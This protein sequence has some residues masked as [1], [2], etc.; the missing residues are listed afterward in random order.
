MA[1]FSPSGLGAL[2]RVVD[3]TA[4][5]GE[6]PG[7][8]GLVS[9]GGETHVFTAGTLA[10]G[11]DRPMRRDTLFRITS[12]TK[13]VTAA[14]AMMLIEEG[15]LALEDPVGRLAPELAV[16]TVLPSLDAP[17]S[18][19]A[20]SPRP[21]TVEDVM[22]FRLGWGVIMAPPGT[23]PVQHVIAEQQ[24][25]G[26]G[27]PDPSV[28]YGPDEYLRRLGQLPLFSPPGRDWRYTTGSNVMGALIPRA[29]GRPLP[30]VFKERIFEPLGMSDTAFHVPPDKLPRLPPAYS[31]Q[32]VY[33]PPDGAW[34]RRPAFPQGDSG[35]VST[36]DDFAAFARF[37]ETGRDARGRALLSPKS[38]AAMKAN[39]LTP[40][41]ARRGAPFLAPG[42][43]WGYG[44]GVM[45]DEN[46]QGLPVG[47]YGWMGGFG[48]SWMTEPG[49]GL[50]ALLMTQR[51]LDGPGGAAMHT[52]FHGAAL[53]AAA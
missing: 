18:A 29:A 5:R 8:V 9:R 19:A 36:A 37:L 15:A 33:D 28:P 48:T 13:P 3:E 53:A 11:G 27:P 50:I 2:Q 30:E 26:F 21:M 14:A 52:A 49:R 20:P 4:A 16:M 7:L 31:A 1:A 46:P 24:L 32:G 40:D 34:S 25:V 35:L 39:H 23:Y 43:G 42:Q 41:Q 38:L 22:S 12:M 17:L 47:T 10:I 45:F 6:A 44:V 51:M